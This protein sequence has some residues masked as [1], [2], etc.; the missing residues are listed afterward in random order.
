MADVTETRHGPA[1]APGGR[2]APGIV[3]IFSESASVRV[4]QPMLLA[5]ASRIGRDAQ[6]EMAVDD[7]QISRLHAQIAPAPGG[8]RVQD[9]GS[10]NGTWVGGVR[11]DVSGAFAPY[12]TIIRCGRTLMRVVQDALVFH[13]GSVDSVGPLVGGPGLQPVRDLI[14]EIGPLP[15]SVLLGGET[16]TGKEVVARALHEASGRRGELVSVNCGALP[17]D[18]VESELFG[19]A[20]GAFSG[21]DRAR[22]GLLRAADNGTLLLDELGELPLAAQAKLLRAMEDK[23]VRAVGEDRPVAVDARVI[24]ATNVDLQAAITRGAFRADL[25]HRVAVWQIALPALRDRSDDVPLLS[26]YFLATD[27]AVMTVEAMERLVLAPW[28]G[29]V[30]ELRNAVMTAAA[31]ARA[32][33]SPAIRP[34]HLPM[35]NAPPPAASKPS[36]DTK[37]AA[38]RARI[39]TALELRGGNVSQVAK[40]LDCTRPWLYLTIKRLGIDAASFRKK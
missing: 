38:L 36:G 18:L 15:H 24:G 10:R 25:F 26:K 2:V 31:R 35:V 14:R 37:T 20:R 1:G 4:M 9:L 22:A 12:G 27:P 29:N 11:T 39:E 40:D 21:S 30:R 13:P 5:G 28:P 23:L 3:P 17:A 6:A 19:H 34:E 32:A 7:S 33:G 16:G 8:V